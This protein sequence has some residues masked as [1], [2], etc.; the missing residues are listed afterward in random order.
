GQHPQAPARPGDLGGPAVVRRPR[1][2][3]AGQGGV[4]DRRGGGLRQGQ[5][6]RSHAH[7]GVRPAGRGGDDVRA[8]TLWHR[9]RM[10][11][12]RLRPV[13]E[14][15]K[16]RREGRK[17]KPRGGEE[18]GGRDGWVFFRGEPPARRERT[19]R[20]RRKP[21]VTEKNRRGVANKGEPAVPRPERFVL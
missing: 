7:P 21:R 5:R 15:K 12:R 1:P 3:P 20:R 14:K 9:T 2:R 13:P 19:V 17:G 4:V 11:R 8:E 6:G 10:R 16:D 18:G